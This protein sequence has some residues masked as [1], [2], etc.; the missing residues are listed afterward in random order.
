MYCLP[1]GGWR[2][3]LYSVQDVTRATSSLVPSLRQGFVL[4]LEP[5][6]IQSMI[7]L[8]CPQLHPSKYQSD[9]NV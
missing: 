9:R 3:A 4:P 8:C 6:Y 2:T 5:H 1:L 7:L